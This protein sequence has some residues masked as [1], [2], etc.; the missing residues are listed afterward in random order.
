MLQAG[1]GSHRVQACVYSCQLII[2]E[3]ELAGFRTQYTAEG[4]RL[5][6]TVKKVITVTYTIGKYTT[7]WKV[8]ADETAN[9]ER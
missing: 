9:R 4:L 8:K 5:G 6:I 2:R 3:S 7:S 1:L